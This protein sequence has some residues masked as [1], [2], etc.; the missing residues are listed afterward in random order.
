MAYDATH[1]VVLLFGGDPDDPRA[2]LLADTWVWN[3]SWA[4]LHPATSP[5]ARFRASMVFDRI[6]NQVILFGGR[7]LNG[8]Y[9]NDTWVW[10]GSTWA[11]PITHRD[12]PAARSQ[13]AYDPAANLA[14]LTNGSETW[15]WDGITWTRRDVALSPI[16]GE[17]AGMSAGV[18]GRGV[19]LF[20]GGYCGGY[21][22]DVTRAPGAAQGPLRVTWFWDGNKWASLA[23]S[24]SPTPLCEPSM[25]YDSERRENVVFGGQ[26]GL[27][28]P[29][30]DET[31]IWDGSTWTQKQTE[32]HP[33]ARTEA[34]MAYDSSRGMV[35]LFGGGGSHAC[36]GGNL[37]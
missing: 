29:T 24:L 6:R 32:T 20:G 28:G 22:V 15:T 26:S 37:L 12:P 36:F 9:M 11:A 25:A 17:E 7:G 27:C 13:M 31:W 33:Q 35:V 19:I 23:P 16:G 3:G 10:D 8:S 21:D 18:G 14:V 1:R 2:E 4:R 34:S 30:S 5:S